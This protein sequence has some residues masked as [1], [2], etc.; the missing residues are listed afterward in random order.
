[1]LCDP[2]LVQKLKSYWNAEGAK[3][4]PTYIPINILLN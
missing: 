4:L 2:Q 1:M 3:D